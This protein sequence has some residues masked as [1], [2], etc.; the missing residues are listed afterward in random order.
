MLKDCES[1]VLPLG[2]ETHDYTQKSGHFSG[3]ILG[4]ISEE[5]STAPQ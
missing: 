1:E 4:K 2:K 3:L 5:Q